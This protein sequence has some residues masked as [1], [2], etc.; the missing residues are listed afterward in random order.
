M[1]RKS[2]SRRGAA[3]SPSMESGAH[4]AA[5][6]NS[7]GSE[8]KNGLG[9]EGSGPAAWPGW[10][11]VVV[12]VAL[13]FHMAAVLAGALGV[14]PS[15]L[16]ERAIADV[17]TPYY[18]PGGPGVLVSV[19]RRAAADAGGHG[20]APVWR[21][22]AGGDGAAAGAGGGGP[23]DASPAAVG[24]GQC[25]VL[26]DVQEAKQRTGDASQSRLA[27]AYARHLCR[28]RPGCRS[29]TLHLQ[30]HLIPEPGAGA[31]G[32]RDARR[33]AVR[34]VRRVA[35]HHARVDR[36]LPVRRLLNEI[37]RLSGRAGRAARGGWNAFFFSPGRPDAPWG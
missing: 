28:T 10:A 5:K 16:L 9:S 19:L 1:R 6:A 12:S 23:A 4:G 22:A 36:R 20:H 21:R 3:E 17:F 29:V 31:R 33:A 2:L 30:Q 13:L 11:R 35:V 18:R 27:R 24:P 26:M 34:P 32:D 14:P 25:A 37:R 15:S 7:S 8:S